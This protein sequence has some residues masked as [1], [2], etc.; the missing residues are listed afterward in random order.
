MSAL[1][2]EW[3]SAVGS[4]LRADFADRDRRLASKF[5]Q[6]QTQAHQAGI[7][8]S[9]NLL[10][11]VFNLYSDEL[12]SRGW[13]IWNTIVRVLSSISPNGNAPEEKEIHTF[14]KERISSEARNFSKAYEEFQ[15]R[16]G[17]PVPHSFE[18]VEE[19]VW[20]RIEFEIKLFFDN[21][22]LGGDS[23]TTRGPG[24]FI[25]APFGTVQI[26]QTNI[27][28]VH[29]QFGHD[30]QQL[31]AA[32]ENIRELLERNIGENNQTVDELKGVVDECRKELEANPPNSTKLLSLLG[33]L[34]NAIQTISSIGPAYQVL[35][36]ALSAYGMMLP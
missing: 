1:D 5:A 22:D 36:V 33:G 9:S 28:H 16:T 6:V 34:A 3:V 17:I 31:L 18:E 2:S 25:S 14:V 10:T 11:S 26:G 23:Q 27:T 7:G 35:R 32:L 20:A 4:R 12:N 13:L 24:I 8:R 29:Q 15:A 19:R 21:R 30:D